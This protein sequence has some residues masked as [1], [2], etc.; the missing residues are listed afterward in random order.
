MRKIRRTLASVFLLASGAT[1]GALGGV[2]GA[3]PAAAVSGPVAKEWLSTGDGAQTLT[4]QPT[5]RFSPLTGRETSIGPSVVVDDALT[6]QTLTGYGAALTDSSAYLI[7]RLPAS[8]RKSLL[9]SLFDPDDATGAHLSIVRLPLGASDFV[10]GAPYSYDDMPAGQ[11]DPDLS[12]FSIA[13]D[14]TYLIPLLREIRSINPDVEVLATP[15]SAPGWMK[16]NDSLI[17]GSL[18]PADES[19]YARYL[20]RTLQSYA[21]AGVPIQVLSVQNEPE[22]DTTDYPGMVMPEAQEAQFVAQYLGPDLAAAG[23][24]P[25]LLGYD[26]NWDDTTYPVQLLQS[27]AAPYLSGVGFHCYA[28]DVSAQSVLHAAAPSAAIWTTECTGGS[29]ATNYGDNLV[30]N[31]ENMVIGAGLNWSTGVLW[32]NV[33]L[34]P[35]GGPHTGGCVGCQ[36]MVTIDPSTGAVTDNVEYWSAAQ[37]AIAARRGAVRVGSTVVGSDTVAALAWRNPDGSHALVAVN[38]GSTAASFSIQWDG[39]SLPATLPAGA[40]ATWSW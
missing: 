39:W 33:A 3:S 26:H 11:T 12:D 38:S 8:R 24:H 35:S 9:N 25:Q 10:V 4:P 29:W 37:A 34:D 27:V 17:G 13:R 7:S 1:V 15:W 5:G 32:W 19:V 31:A 40:V 18:L 14:E 28:G 30:W 36:G 22:N 23:L 6:G 16:N 20:V 21:A 2:S